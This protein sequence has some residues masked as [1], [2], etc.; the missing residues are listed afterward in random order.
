MA[1]YSDNGIV[2]RTYKYSEADRIAVFL[3]ENHGKVRAI[4]KGVRK[5]TSKLGGRVEPGSHSAVQFFEGKSDLHKVI[6]VDV[7]DTFA[8]I[9]G[10]YDRLVRV[11]SILEVAEQLSQ[12]H[13]PNPALYRMVLGAVRSL[14][15]HDSPLL[16]TAFFFKVL[17]LEGFRP[18]IDVCVGCGGDPNNSDVELVSFDAMEGTTCRN[19]RRGTSMSSEALRIIRLILGGQLGAALNEPESAFTHEVETLAVRSVE[20]HLE[21]R[22]RSHHSA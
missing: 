8:N 3:T 12:D 13:E 1:L 11:A 22:L 15:E 20:G 9:R 7:L 21:R 19:C 16:V 17:A 14:N 18:E 5:T 2:I 4:A 10:D 6:Q